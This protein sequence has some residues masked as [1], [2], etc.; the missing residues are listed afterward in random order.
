VRDKEPVMEI[1]V[2]TDGHQRKS[3]LTVC[4]RSMKKVCEA[5]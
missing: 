2:G 3:T 4:L 1:L 5:S